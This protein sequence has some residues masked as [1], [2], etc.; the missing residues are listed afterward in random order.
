MT[1]SQWPPATPAGAVRFARGTRDL[2]ACQDFYGGLLR[3]P[4][5]FAFEADNADG[6]RGVIFGVPDTSLTLE[7]IEAERSGHLD[8]HDQLVLYTCRAPSVLNRSPGGSW[9]RACPA[10]HAVLLL[11]AARRPHL[12]RSRRPRARPRTLDLRRRQGPHADRGR[13]RRPAAQLITGADD[14]GLS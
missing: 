6:I 11:G 3:L 14:A 13:R 8:P 5:L 2:Q 7:F 1:G 10:A 12:H 9:T 4:F